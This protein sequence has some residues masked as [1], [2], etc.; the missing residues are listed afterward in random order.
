M[1][2][3]AAVMST[4]DRETDIL[5]AALTVLARDGVGGVSM[6]AVA[7]EAGVS[8][9]LTNYYFTDKTS[10]IGAALHR[11][12][13]HDLEIVR[14]PERGDAATRL[15]RALR[16][17]VAPEFLTAEYLALRLQLWS[18]AV[19]DAVYAEINRHAQERYLDELATLIAAAM[20]DLPRNEAERRASEILVIQNGIWLTAAIVDD[21][22]A[23][24]SSVERCMQIA[25]APAPTA[26][27]KGRRR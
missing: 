18:L 26:D 25:F 10:L 4:R 17:V 9:G 24:A 2:A 27:G 12:G 16:R 23:R 19:V 21:D 15:R 8:L 22:G 5:D 3:S 6:R 11:I 7:R 14:P 20:C 13:E 1:T